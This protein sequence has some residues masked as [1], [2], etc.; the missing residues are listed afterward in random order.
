MKYGLNRSAAGDTCANCGKSAE[1][2][3]FCPHCGAPLTIS[4]IATYEE[5][6]QKTVED[7]INTLKYIA[8]ENKTDSLKDVL[9]IFND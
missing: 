1:N 8:K 3:D 6:H 7:V 9:K 5:N 4:A 2:K